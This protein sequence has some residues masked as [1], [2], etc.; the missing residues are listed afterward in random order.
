MHNPATSTEGNANRW[1]S[2]LGLKNKM[3]LDT[4]VTLYT[5]WAINLSIKWKIIKQLEENIGEKSMWNE[6]KAVLDTTSKV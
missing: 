1:N 3:K 4:D 6:V 2:G 5:K